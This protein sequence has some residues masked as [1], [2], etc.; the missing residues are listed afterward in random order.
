M[1]TRKRPLRVL[2]V[3]G[4]RPEAIKMAPV[5]RALVAAPERFESLVCLSAQHRQMLDQIIRAFGLKVDFD[6]DLMRAGQTPSEVASKVLA[7]MPRVFAEARPDI[8][9]VQGDTTTTAATSMAAFMSGVPVAH[10]EAGLRTD[11]IR[12]PFPEEMNRRLATLVSTLHFPPTARARDALLREGVAAAKITVTGNTV[13]DALLSRVRADYRFES[14]ELAGLGNEG[15]MVLVTLHRRESFG[16]PMRSV[17]RA[18]KTIAARHPDLRF[19]LPVHPN[20]RVKEVVEPELGGHPQFA[21]T[22]PLEYLDF[23]HAMARSCLIVTD[24]GGVQEEAP[25]LN[26]PVLVTR[27]VTER[28]EG[29]ETGAAL[30]VG[31]DSARIVEAIERLLTDPA[32]YARMAA[33]SNPYGD[34]H[35]SERI[36]EALDDWASECVFS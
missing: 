5:V 30:L 33:A 1:L 27:E 32:A 11:D 19:V 34:G 16:E 22:Q 14:S 29:V 6:L 24:S 23:I 8:V 28:P 26:R 9:V 4:T 20:P 15:R 25:A 21:L 3:F 17:C 13:I 12:Q 7:S 10:V 35:A 31:T 18:L 36:I 2:S